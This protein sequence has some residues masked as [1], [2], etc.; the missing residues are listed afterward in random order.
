MLVTNFAVTLKDRMGLGIWACN[1]TSNNLL[2]ATVLYCSSNTLGKKQN[3]KL[4]AKVRWQIAGHQWSSTDVVRES[5]GYIEW[6]SKM[7]LSLLIKFLVTVEMVG[8]I[9]CSNTKSAYAGSYFSRIFLLFTLQYEETDSEQQQICTPFLRT[10]HK[11][12]Q[13]GRVS[14]VHSCRLAFGRAVSLSQVYHCF[15]G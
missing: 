15:A 3:S 8:L 9:V 10:G 14:H 11:H 13:K 12:M 1:I 4:S 6:K 2:K 7:D 5:H